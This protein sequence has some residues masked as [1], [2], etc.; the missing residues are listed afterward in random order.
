M[1]EIDAIWGSLRLAN[2][3]RQ[4]D[5]SR[6][7]PLAGSTSL[8]PFRLPPPDARER[9]GPPRYNFAPR[10]PASFSIAGLRT[11]A[12]ISAVPVVRIALVPFC[13]ISPE[14]LT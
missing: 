5:G 1:G 11:F 2:A 12:C 8:K 7:G 14:Y 13:A 6:P 9:S 3:R 10:A 4:G